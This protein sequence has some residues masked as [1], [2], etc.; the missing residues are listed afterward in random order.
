MN[1]TAKI[2]VC[3][4]SNTSTNHMA[5]AIK[6]V[7]DLKGKVVRFYSSDTKNQDPRIEDIDV[8]NIACGMSPEEI[9]DESSVICCTAYMAGSKA[10]ARRKFDLVIVNDAQMAKDTECV[11]PFVRSTGKVVFVGDHKQ[12]GPIISCPHVRMNGGEVSL[13]D[14]LIQAGKQ[15]IMLTTQ[16][17]MHPAIAA[18]VSK[19]F[20]KGMIQNGVSANDRTNPTPDF[21]WPNPDHPIAFVDVDGREET[22]DR[23]HSFMNCAEADSVIAILEK[24]RENGVDSRRIGVITPYQAQRE[25]IEEKIMRLGN[26][27]YDDVKIAP[28]DGFQGSERDY[29]IL[30]CV[31]NNKENTIG[32]LSDVRRVNVM[33][34]RA[35]CG[36]ILVGNVSFME[37]FHPWN[38]LI[39]HFMEQNVIITDF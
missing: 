5:Y 7:D 35:R 32:F 12:I 8:M 29:I 21:P 9:L 22:S 31:R 37:Q 34:T 38:E 19:I 4:P 15:P 14:R 10:I 2:L 25:L 23:T 13:F 17:R 36:L 16:Y 3:S 24:F 28:V 1:P 20:Y 6:H 11:V 26:R 18:P 30:T 27:W 33:F 39:R